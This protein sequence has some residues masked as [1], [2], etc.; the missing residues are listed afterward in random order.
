MA[1]HRY[2]DIEIIITS[3]VN[4]LRGNALEK[5]E[6]VHLDENAVIMYECNNKQLQAVKCKINLHCY[7]AFGQNKILEVSSIAL[8]EHLRKF[9]IQG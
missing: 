6:Q 7:K 4:G 2:S 1:F 8:A 9:N 5:R 3:V